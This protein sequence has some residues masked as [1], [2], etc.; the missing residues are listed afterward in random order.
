MKTTMELKINGE[1]KSVQENTTVLELLLGLEL[2]PERVAI[3]IN[4]KILEKKDFAHRPLH[5]NDHLEIV[6]FVGGG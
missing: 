1:L 2:N 4:R 6:T 3:E 5:A